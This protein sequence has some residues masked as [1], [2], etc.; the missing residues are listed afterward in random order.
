MNNSVFGKMTEN[1]R[2]HRDINL[3]TN[4]EVYLKR[5]LKPNFRS[6]I[7]FSKNLMGCEMGKIQVTMNKPVY[8]GQAIFDLSKTI[9]YEFHYDYMK[10]RYGANLQ[11]CYMDTDSLVYN[12]KTD[13]FYEDITGN[14]KARFDMSDYSHSHPLP[15]GVNKEGYWPYEG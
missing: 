10:M 7:V 15:M 11:L 14:V 1:I 8:L 3:V 6:G 2:K 4:E 5:M 13:N 9:M 12:I